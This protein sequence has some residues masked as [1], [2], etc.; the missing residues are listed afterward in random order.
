LHGLRVIL[1]LFFRATLKNYYQTLGV[2][3]SATRQEI[4]KA[5]RALAKQLHPDVNNNED[6]RV[7]FIEVHQ[8][9]EFLMDDA[10][11]RNYDMMMSEER[12]SRQ[13]LE[14]R[15]QIYK[16]WVEHQQRQAIRRTAME[17]YHL[18]EERNPFEKRFWKG[19]NLVYNIIFLI[20]FSFIIVIPW[21]N[22][23]AE[24]EL[25]PGRQRHFIYFLMPSLTGILF[26]SY[27][28]YYWFMVRDEKNA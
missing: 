23:A 21:M 6:A 9:Y 7:R 10:Q 19:I 5:Y 18:A 12:L 11:R 27:S 15:E 1:A 24:Q 14:R 8:A 4:R 2:D 22:Y 13:E 3:R 16:L 28:Y 26:L 20:L 17:S 25:E